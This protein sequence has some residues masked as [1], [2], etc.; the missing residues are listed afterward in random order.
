M[1]FRPYQQ[2]CSTKQKNYFK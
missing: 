1:T 2:R